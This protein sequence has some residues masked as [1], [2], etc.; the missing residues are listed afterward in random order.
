MAHISR[1]PVNSPTPKRSLIKDHAGAVLRYHSSLTECTTGPSAPAPGVVTGP[2]SM[3]RRIHPRREI[4]SP[5]RLAG[6]RTRTCRDPHRPPGNVPPDPSRDS[7][8]PWSPSDTLPPWPTLIIRDKGQLPP[9]RGT[10]ESGQLVC[11]HRRTR[12]LTGLLVMRTTRVG[13][14]GS[15]TDHLSNYQPPA[16]PLTLMTLSADPTGFHPHWCHARPHKGPVP[17]LL[18]PPHTPTGTL[19]RGEESVAQP[20]T[21]TS[22][23]EKDLP[24]VP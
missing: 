15:E 20:Q 13:S 11:H 17:R 12:L 16:H 2:L 6:R 22:T 5:R 10:S 1:E 14:V 9:G 24:P 8:R 21:E 18:W 7:N 4:P 19:A 3:A 23:A